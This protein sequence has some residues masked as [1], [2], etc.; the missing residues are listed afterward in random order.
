MPLYQAGSVYSGVRQAK[1]TAGQRRI[2]TEQQRQAVIE[3]ITSAWTALQSASD[4]IRSNIDLVEA[5]EIALEG[6]TQEAEVG[7]RTTLDVL[8]SEQELLDAQ[9]A[10][11]RAERDEFVAG[12]DLRAAIGSLSAEA[13]ALPVDPYNP[14]LNYALVRRKLFGLE[15]SE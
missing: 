12:F 1:Q 8:D 9:V 15:V 4:L 5:A 14:E 6:V 11:V 13:L 7:A 2:E 3:S 10:L